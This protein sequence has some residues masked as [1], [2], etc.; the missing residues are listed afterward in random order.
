MV[1]SGE[2]KISIVIAD[3]H[4]I[5]REGIKN[6]IELSPEFEVIGMADNG[7]D[8]LAICKK[9]RPDVLLLDISMPSMSGIETMKRL[10]KYKLKTRV[11]ALTIHDEKAYLVETLSLG[12]K[13]YVLKDAD[14][15]ILLEAIR[16]VHKGRE[17]IY[18]SMRKYLDKKTKKMIVSGKTDVF[19]LLTSRELEIIKFL[20][21]GMSNKDIS[22]AL[23]ISEKTVKNHVSNIFSKLGIN[24]RTSAAMYAVKKGLIKV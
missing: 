15:D 22:D 11:I 21:Q 6:L 8:A 16:E 12:V 9:E 17:Y 23:Y 5:V 4:A 3:D 19:G 1:T 7:K 18:P 20:A 13:G 10:M 2:G 14:S 24:D